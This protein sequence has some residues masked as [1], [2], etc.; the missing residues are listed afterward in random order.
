MQQL[1]YFYVNKTGN[2]Q[3][4]PA[5][6]IYTYVYVHIYIRT[7]SRLYTFNP[8]PKAVIHSVFYNNIFCVNFSSLIESN[9]TYQHSSKYK[10]GLTVQTLTHMQSRMCCALC[11]CA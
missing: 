8:C 3:F 6:N 1:Q 10:E 4:Y 11:V 5:V 9:S 7:H 2:A